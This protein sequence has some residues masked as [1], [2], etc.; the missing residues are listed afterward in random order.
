MKCGQKVS[1]FFAGVM[2]AILIVCIAVPAMAATAGKSIT[3]YPGVGLYIDDTKLIPK[4][5]NGNPV[6]VFFYNGT[7]YVP[8]RA[9]SEAFGYPVQWDGDTRS[10][11][12]GKH[13]GDKP[14]VWLC[15]MDYSSGKKT[16][17]T[18]DID[19]D[20]IGNSHYHCILQTDNSSVDRSYYINNQYSRIS[21]VL[22]QRYD[23]RSNR[24]CGTTPSEFKIYGDGELL[25]SHEFSSGSTG[26]KPIN[27]DV[28]ISGILEIKIYLYSGLDNIVALG[29]VGLWT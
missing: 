10:V 12:I 20:N 7:T 9:V 17:K 28:D 8:I 27:F 19:K 15:N 29:D 2:T 23:A 14:A 18:L 26:I 13:T 11:Y 4:D 25:Y 1:Y 22:Y 21:G 24:I 16:V 6:E 5:V 3:V